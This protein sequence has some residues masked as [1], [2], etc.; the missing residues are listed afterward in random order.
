MKTRF[1]LL[2]PG[3]LAILSIPCFP[4]A[5][6][7]PE[8]PAAAGDNAAVPPSAPEHPAPP[9]PGEEES[10]PAA[11]T[12]AGD[13]AA[14][15]PSA[16]EPASLPVPETTEGPPA[17]IPPAGDNAA[18]ID[19]TW[20]DRSHDY[21]EKML[22]STADW[23]DRSLG[24]DALQG[25]RETRASLWWKN[26]FRYDGLQHYTFR[27]AFRAGIRLPR[28]ADRW[29]VVIAGENKGDPTAAIPVDPGTPGAN[30]ASPDRRASGG[31]VYD[32]FRTE[33]TYFNL[34]GGVQFDFPIDVYGRARFGYVQP[35]GRDTLGRLTVTGA[36]HAQDGPGVS[37]QLDFEHRLS[38]ATQ[39][40]WSNSASLAEDTSG[41]AWGT[42]L[43][44]SHMLT[45][46]SSVRIG[47]SVRGDTRP[48]FEVQN[49]RVYAGYRRNIFRPW[50]FVE[51]EPDVN[52]PLQ[53]DGP[54]EPVYGATLRLEVFF[55]GKGTA[56]EPSQPPPAVPP[57]PGGVP[58][59]DG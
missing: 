9:Q 7:T 53:G 46:S 52:W 20:W 19:K 48:A 47:G 31:L 12:P 3:W 26:D 5:V 15:P 27:T 30:V 14:V 51:L 45:W 1:L 59:E 38:Q 54:R 58:G 34:G 35:L 39:M 6:D 37:N 41:W 33:Q 13:N 29:R 25:S 16:P 8:T 56:P 24:G 42:E 55:L 10:P 28:L 40:V 18:R 11:I 4:H 50:L 32:I 23:L 57:P 21:V 2:L 36:Y 44:L 49:Y 17:A 43:S 22:F